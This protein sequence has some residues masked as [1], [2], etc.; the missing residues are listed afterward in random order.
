MTATT[1]YWRGY[2]AYNDNHTSASNPYSPGTPD[3]HD[4]QCGFYDARLGSEGYLV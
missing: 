4:W 1:A 2:A 3:W